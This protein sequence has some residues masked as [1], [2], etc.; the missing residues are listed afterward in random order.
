MPHHYGV[1]SKTRQKFSKSFREKGLPNVSRYLKVFREGDF[2]DIVA[3]PSIHKGMPFQYYH[4]RTGKVFGV[5][6]NA[7]GIE[8]T[9]LV[10]GR[11]FL[12]RIYVRIE[13][14]RRSRCDAEIKARVQAN[15]AAKKEAKASGK[16]VVLKRQPKGPRAGCIVKVRNASAVKVLHVTPYAGQDI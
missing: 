7:L 9:K 16:K 6:K 5:F 1:R 8:V 4:G 2:V 15:E 12:K 13:H 14:V 3:D 10:R 11:E